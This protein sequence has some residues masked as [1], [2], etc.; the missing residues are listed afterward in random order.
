MTD[1]LLVPV[2]PLIETRRLVL[3]SFRGADAPALHSAL[4]E[5]VNELRR[6]PWFLPWV[7]EEPTLQAAELRCREAGANFLLRTDLP[8]LGFE[9]ETGRLVCSMGLHRTDWQLPKTEVGYW[10]RTSE[11]GKG[12][13]REGVA[14]LASWALDQLKAKRVELVTDQENTASRRVA[15]AC[16]FVLEGTLHNVQASPDGTLRHTCVYAKLPAAA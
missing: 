8:Y 11:A 12:Y 1:P 10:V 3:R 9:R 15:E 16:G 6:F 7:A 13:A 5:S 4:A 14:A 2:P